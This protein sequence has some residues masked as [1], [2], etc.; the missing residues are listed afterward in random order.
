[1]HLRSR[2]VRGN[3]AVSGSLNGIGRAA[4]CGPRQVGADECRARRH[5]AHRIM[6][7]CGKGRR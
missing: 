7:A 3:T 2:Y 1:V 5:V 4:N 6:P